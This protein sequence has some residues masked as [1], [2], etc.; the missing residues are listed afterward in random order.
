MK[1]S[2]RTLDET[3][4]ELDSDSDIRQMIEISENDIEEGLIF[5]STDLIEHIKNSG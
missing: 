1:F 2:M 3:V 4:I 5:S